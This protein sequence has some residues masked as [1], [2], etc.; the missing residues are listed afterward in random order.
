MV[1]LEY[2]KKSDIL[3]QSSDKSVRFYKNIQSKL[4]MKFILY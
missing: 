4:E 1:M 2:Q 3:T